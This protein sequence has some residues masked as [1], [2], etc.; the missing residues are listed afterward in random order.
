MSTTMRLLRIA[1]VF[2]VCAAAGANAQDPVATAAQRAPENRYNLQ[3]FHADFP[4]ALEWPPG[5]NREYDRTRRQILARLAANLQGNVRRETWQ[6]T[7]EFFWRAPDDAVEPLTEAMDRA[8]GN[9]ALQDFVRNCVEAMGKMKNPR[10][11][12]ALRRAAEHVNPAV[13]QGAFLALSASSSLETLRAMGGW[14]AQLDGRAR[15]A[16]L[17]A[18][19][20]RLPADCVRLLGE[21]MAADYPAQV[22]DEVMKEALLLPAEQA[23]A[24]VRCRW[25]DARG[26]TKATIAGVLHAA[27]DLSGTT[28]I[29]EALQGE[30]LLTMGFAIRHSTFGDPGTLRADLLRASTHARPE[31]RLEVA[32]ALVGVDGDDVADVYETFATPDEV[33]EI[34][35]IALPQLTRRGRGNTVAALLED[36]KTATGTHMQLLLT[37]LSVSGD[38]RAVPVLVER[39]RK[40]PA[41]EGRPFLQAISQNG[42]AAAA[43]AMLE[44]FRGPETLVAHGSNGDLTTLNYVPILL[45]NVRGGDQQIMDG[46]DA[47]ARE[48]WR[49]RALL[50]PSLAGLAA[51]RKDVAVQQRCVETLRR[52]LFD[53]TEL[54]QLRVLALNL[55]TLRWITVEDALK[56]KNTHRDEQVGLKTLIADYLNEFF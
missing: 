18:V 25:A 54:P 43:T 42:S 11:D 2:V 21:V 46:Y 55:M 39:F 40:A 30:D 7:T 50:L 52:V 6:M 15:I 41:G 27:G 10:F 36:M 29:Q 12:A 9:V 5:H 3:P 53:R 47:I 16:W 37:Q 31:I 24:V 1:G 56:L 22:R 20:T 26:E 19:R 51:D 49:R 34:K 38:G 23:A 28:W 44:L 48:D 17:Q 45:Q 35:V 33:W 13:R 4:V 8:F 32:K 14:F